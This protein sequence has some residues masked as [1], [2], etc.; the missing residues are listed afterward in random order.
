[1]PVGLIGPR[2][3]DQFIDGQQGQCS[4]GRTKQVPHTAVEE[5]A[6]HD[7]RGDCFHFIQRPVSDVAGS[8]RQ[9]E[10]KAGDSGG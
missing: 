3:P 2:R 10:H 9:Q 6:T 8:C 7:I 4:D 5:D 1:M